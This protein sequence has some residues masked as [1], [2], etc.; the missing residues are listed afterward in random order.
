MVPLFFAVP[1]ILSAIAKTIG[2]TV[3][4]EVTRRVIDYGGNCNDGSHDHRT[5]RG[6]D[7][8]PAQ[9]NGDRRRR[10]NSRFITPALVLARAL[11]RR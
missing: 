10:K 1:P 2:I 5:N 6:D 4:T 7:R 11:L 8:T 3:A 9:K